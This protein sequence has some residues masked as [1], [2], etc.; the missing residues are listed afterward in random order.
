MTAAVLLAL[1]EVAPREIGAALPALAVLCARQELDGGWGC[2]WWSDALQATWRALRAL[3]AYGVCEFAGTALGEPSR[4]LAQH[5][6]E[7]A[8]PM[9]S[10]LAVPREPVHLGLW[11]GSWAEAGG[12]I[13]AA[14]RAVAALEGAPAA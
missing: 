9:L 2:F 14:G 12:E 1:L 13:D 8:L 11:L 10:G 7:R 5:A 3:R 4:L 6:V